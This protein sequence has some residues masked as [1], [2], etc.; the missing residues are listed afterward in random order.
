[1]HVL[2]EIKLKMTFIIGFRTKIMLKLSIRTVIVN[3]S[4]CTQNIVL[5]CN[6]GLTQYHLGT[7]G[8]PRPTV[9]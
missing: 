5:D 7:P 8:V 6:K 3:V 2:K 4:T 9:A 1:M